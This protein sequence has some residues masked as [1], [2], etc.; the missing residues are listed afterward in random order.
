MR[1]SQVLSGCRCFG[2]ITEL[3]M[4]SS[5]NIKL[6]G[7]TFMGELNRDWIYYLLILEG[8]MLKPKLHY[9]GHLMQRANSLQRPWCWR[10][11]EGKRRGW[12]RMRWLDSI[13]DSMDMN[14]SKLWETVED[15]G[16]WPAAVYWVAKSWAWFRDWKTITNME[17]PSPAGLDLKD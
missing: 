17:M 15:R 10:K 12:Q 3:F 8:L 1:L 2:T 4:F 6:F 14:M 5:K 11:I 16:G 9:F 7:I 13:T